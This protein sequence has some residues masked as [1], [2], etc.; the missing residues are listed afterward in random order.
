MSR[1][2]SCMASLHS[3]PPTSQAES[4]SCRAAEAPSGALLPL[5]PAACES[6]VLISSPNRSKKPPPLPSLQPCKG[7]VVR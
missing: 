5:L 6:T 4:S 3:R 7:S 1:G 2:N